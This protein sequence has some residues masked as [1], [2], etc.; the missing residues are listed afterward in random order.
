MRSRQQDTV[1]Q[2]PDL[3]HRALVD[4]Q[5]RNFPDLRILMNGWE[6][7]FPGETP[8][9]L[10]ARLRDTVL[11]PRASAQSANAMNIEK[12]GEMRGNML[13][14]ALRII[15]AQASTELGSIQQHGETL[16]QETNPKSQFAILRIMAEELRH[17][18]QMFWILCA[19]SSWARGGARRLTFETLDELI[20]MKTGAHVLDA[21][22]IPFQDELDNVVF[23]FSI[24]R[25]G[26]YQLSMQKQFSYAPMARSMA[27]ML[28][29][30]SF[31]LKTGAHLL[32]RYV[33]QAATETGRWSLDEIQQRI[34][35]WYPRAADM[36]GNP[37]GGDAAVYFGF[38][39]MRNSDGLRLF[40]SEVARLIKR[41]NRIA[42]SARHPQLK[43]TQIEEQFDGEPPLTLP[44]DAFFR[45][46]LSSPEL[47]H[48]VD[49]SGRPL[50]ACAYE[51]YLHRH[52][53]PA[54][55]DTRFFHTYIANAGMASAG[56]ET[57]RPVSQGR[58]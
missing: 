44:A 34:N 54:F 58:L 39:T 21:F 43:L 41:L 48:P 33:A 40:R 50:P 56:I 26:K 2:L 46:R 20:E 16:A 19:D 28:E 38:K 51:A 29:E 10:N 1:F 52:L 35:Q 17:A 31:H 57:S 47:T 55:T 15:K 42:L 3:Y 4:W 53:S 27:P 37:Q 5:K 13:Y 14:A 22:N 9:V 7:Y 23:A 8:F 24:D 11:P 6:K 12:A 30:E 18:Y 25:V 49:I 32:S 36:F 45:A